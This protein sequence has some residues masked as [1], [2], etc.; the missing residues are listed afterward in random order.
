MNQKLEDKLRS[1]HQLPEEE[2]VRRAQSGDQQAFSDLYEQFYPVVHKRV[3]YLI[4]TEDV[5]DVT[6]EIFIAMIRSLKTFRGDSKF[7]TWLRVITNRQIANYYRSNSKILQETELE[8]TW[9][10]TQAASPFS[11]RVRQ[12][13]K[14]LAQ[15]G[16]EN[17]PEKYQEIILLRFAEGLRFKEIAAL[18]G[19]SLDATKSTF[20]RA[21][22]AMRKALGEEHA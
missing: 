7:S 10:P 1:N 3:A 6:Q 15:Q 20:R 5:D 19:N 8:D 14:I 9:Q 22:E 21:L 2:L 4:P 13:R 12:D 16:L 17:L 11:T 18:Q